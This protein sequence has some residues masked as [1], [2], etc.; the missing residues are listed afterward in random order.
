MTGDSLCYAF[1]KYEEE[2]SAIEAYFKMNKVSIDERRIHVDFS[3]SVAKLD[4]QGAGGWRNFFAQRA[5]VRF[6][7]FL[8]FF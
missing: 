4:W 7:L 8:I 3:Q 1:I 6:F 2:E 5:K